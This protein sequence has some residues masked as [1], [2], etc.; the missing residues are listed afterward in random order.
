[1]SPAPAASPTPDDGL[2]GKAIDGVRGVLG[3]LLGGG[4]PPPSATPTG[5]A[6]G[7]TA[8][9][10]ATTAPATGTASPKATGHATPKAS[11]TAGCPA[12][13]RKLIV[14]ADQTRA[15]ATPS[16]QLTADLSQTLLVYDGVTDLPTANGTIQVLQFS[17]ESSTSTPFELR[18]PAAG[19]RTLVLRSTKLTV[20]GN[21]RFYTT[22]L[23]GK[24]LGIPVTFTPDSPPPLPPVLPVPVLEFTDVTLQL[25]LVHADT[26]TAP[27]L[28]IA[29]AS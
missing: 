11:A 21:V 8:A 19:G 10:S 3:G 27:D 12:T 26:L 2:V 7:P 18:V 4:D 13:P 20:S 6:P 9:G 16:E 15:A 5:A 28:S 22:R 29:Y 17:M 14:A 23:D 1:M 24:L 25:A